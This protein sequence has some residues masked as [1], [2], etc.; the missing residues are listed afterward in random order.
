MGLGKGHSRD[1]NPWRKHNLLGGGMGA[2]GAPTPYQ[3][4]HEMGHQGP[5]S[6]PKWQDGQQVRTPEWIPVMGA[7]LLP[8]W[9]HSAPPQHGAE[10][11]LLPHT[12]I[13]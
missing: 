7:G 10:L 9:G 4:P 11:P 6:K 2:L 8:P 13:S 3:T 5:T 12:S 1:G